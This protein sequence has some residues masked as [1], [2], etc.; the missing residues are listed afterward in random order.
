MEVISAPVCCSSIQAP[1]GDTYDL[2]CARRGKLRSF[3]FTSLRAEHFGPIEMTASSTAFHLS[4]RL[5]AGCQPRCK[6][7]SFLRHG[8][9]PTDS[10]KCC[11]IVFSEEF[12]FRLV[13][14]FQS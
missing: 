12:L 11:S 6:T 9:P 10:V 4:S 8:K 3:H 1:A 7:A 5:S 14:S 13:N 2:V